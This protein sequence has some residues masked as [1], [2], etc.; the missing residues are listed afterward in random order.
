MDGDIFF[1]V[2]ATKKH[3]VEGVRENIM[4]SQRDSAP[5]R[6]AMLQMCQYAVKLFKQTEDKGMVMLFNTIPYVDR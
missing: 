6:N 1:G 5:Q 4:L 2:N 3:C